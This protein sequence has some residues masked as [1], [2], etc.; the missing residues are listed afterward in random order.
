S[1][2]SP[3]HTSRG[4]SGKTRRPSSVRHRFPF[5]S[6]PASIRTLCP[7][8]QDL[9]TASLHLN[10]DAASLRDKPASQPL[11]LTPANGTGFPR[12]YRP[13]PGT[14]APTP[15]PPKLALPPS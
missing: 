8:R 14:S 4:P 11:F 7:K 6:R 3:C 2:P 15:S 5:S 10:L 9:P 13:S 12:P 1:N